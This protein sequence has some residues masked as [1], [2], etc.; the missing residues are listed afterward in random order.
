L[1]T[2]LLIGNDKLSG[3][4]IRHS[5]KNNSL[6]ICVDHSTSL[7]RIARLLAKQSISPL[8]LIKMAFCEL[9]RS[10]SRPNPRLTK[11]RSNAEL[12]K[13]MDKIKP[14]QVILFRAGLIVNKAL[15]DKGITV[16]NIHAAVVPQ[17][18]GLGSIAKAL[19]DEAYEQAACLHR[20][21]ERIDGG[22]VLARE[23]YR[24]DPNVSYC[25]NE[26]TAYA[27]ATRLL[28]ALALPAVRET[29]KSR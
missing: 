26:K 20:V 29:G 22:D 10:G 19:A 8:L 2:L 5:E 13:E 16:L 23:N 11:I 12:V 28:H 15:I 27:A 24:L 9:A 6:H 4:A 17:Y 25:E 3:E 18:G 7:R 1:K 21:T 14:S